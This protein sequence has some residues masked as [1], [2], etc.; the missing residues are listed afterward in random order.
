MSDPAPQSGH[1]R[2]TVDDLTGPEMRDLFR[3]LD[4]AYRAASAAM[5]ADDMQAWV[6]HAAR[7]AEL[8]EHFARLNGWREERS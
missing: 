2:L 8:F 6:E 4:E 3:E 5:A 1:H 7:G